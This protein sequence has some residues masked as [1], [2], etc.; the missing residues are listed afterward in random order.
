MKEFI[1]AIFC[2]P[3][4]P[5]EELNLPSRLTEDVFKALKEVGINRIFGYGYDD[6]RETKIATLKLC[7]KY[8]IGYCPTLSSFSPYI[9]IESEKR[10]AFNN[11]SEE[12]MENYDE[13][14]INE[15]KSYLPYKAFKG[16]FFGDEAGY[17]SFNGIAHAKKVFS[18]N[19]PNLEFHFNFFSYSINEPIFWGGMELSRN[20]NLQYK[21]PF[22]LTK[23][24]SITFKNRFNFY[25][26]LVDHLLSQTHFEYISQDKYPFEPFWKEINNSVHVAL[27]ELNAF[28]A[29]KKRQY[30]FNFYNY[31]QAGQWSSCKN[32][33][34]LK[35]GEMFLQTNITIGYGHEG[36]SYFPGCYPIDFI[37]DKNIEYAKK[38]PAGLIDIN[39][40]KG[41][42]YKWVKKQNEF[43]SLIEEDIIKSDFL[44]VSSCGKYNNGF[45]I[46]DIKDLP[47]NECI[48]I[49]KLPDFVKYRSKNI[50]IQSSNEIMISS[51]KENKKHKYFITNLSSVF[52]NDLLIYF[53]KNKF[54]LI[55]GNKIKKAK[56][57][58]KIKLDP[59]EAIYLIEEI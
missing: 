27:F 18:K 47:D 22:E 54:R 41:E 51:F 56:N 35:K 38:G 28:F 5:Y 49:G 11:L 33:R 34:H 14:L 6:R 21:K 3:T 29:K 12:E 23:E 30:G 40:K 52:K 48:F 45:K 39:G 1:K 31:L 7:E 25:N 17:L 4:G 44:G 8:N 2:A 57:A 53:K 42:I 9:T 36:Y 58:F 43:I 20:P 13:A 15:G 32:R 50:K 46:K 59:G 10:K 24:N 37:F 19:F 55:K 26:L 16:V